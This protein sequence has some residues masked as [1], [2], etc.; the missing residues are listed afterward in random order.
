MAA[1]IRRWDVYVLED[2]DCDPETMDV[3]LDTHDEKGNVNPKFGLWV[4]HCQLINI[5]PFFAGSHMPSTTEGLQI[6]WLTERDV[7]LSTVRKY[8][9]RWWKDHPGDYKLYKEFSTDLRKKIKGYRNDEGLWIPGIPS[10]VISKF[11]SR[12]LGHKS[13]DEPVF[14]NKNSGRMIRDMRLD[15]N[16]VC[17]F[18]DNARFPVGSIRQSFQVSGKKGVVL[19]TPADVYAETH[20]ESF[21]KKSSGLYLH[22]GPAAPGDG[23]AG[24]LYKMVG[25]S[26]VSWGKDRVDGFGQDIREL[27]FLPDGRPGPNV[28]EWFKWCYL[29]SVHPFVPG[30]DWSVDPLG[31][32]SIAGYE[33]EVCLC[34]LELWKKRVPEVVMMESASLYDKLRPLP[35]GQ[36][37]YG[38]L[39]VNKYIGSLEKMSFDDS[40]DSVVDS[41]DKCIRDSRG[42]GVYNIFV[43][44]SFEVAKKNAIR[45]LDNDSSESY[46]LESFDLRPKMRRGVQL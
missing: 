32:L 7:L 20:R 36:R 13:M 25:P 24:S 46:S 6:L 26:L 30:Q 5:H 28:I 22:G 21:G 40:V 38:E 39:H 33:H 11:E 41:M 45:I 29:N 44:R 23:L 35:S 19:K 12:K 42:R 10:D 34:S 9:K 3:F 27:T 43:N 14:F 1:G 16:K 15:R 2:M 18:F 31:K 4:D 37:M 8:G 17:R